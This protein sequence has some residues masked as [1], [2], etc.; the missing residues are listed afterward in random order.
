MKKNIYLFLVAVLLT[1]LGY[2]SGILYVLYQGK[3][4]QEVRIGSKLNTIENIWG[5]PDINNLSENEI[6]HTYDNTPINK[7]VFVYNAKDSLLVKKWKE[8]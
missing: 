5:T 2:I 6:Y 7:Y 4:Y 1:L 8:N 3:K